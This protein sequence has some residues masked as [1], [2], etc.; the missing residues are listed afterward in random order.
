MDVEYNSYLL[1]VMHG[2]ILMCLNQKQKLEVNCIVVISESDNESIQIFV[3][4]ETL[5]Y[6]PLNNNAIK[7]EKKIRITNY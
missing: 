5:T 1:A 6:K 2:R 7:K 3:T 4:G